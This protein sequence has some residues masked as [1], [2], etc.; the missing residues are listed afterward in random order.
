M[1]TGACVGPYSRFWQNHHL[2]QQRSSKKRP[3]ALLFCR[4]RC[5]RCW[6]QAQAA[7]LL[8]TDDL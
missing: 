6:Q 5:R 2:I 8:C 4:C 3:L 7:A 1:T